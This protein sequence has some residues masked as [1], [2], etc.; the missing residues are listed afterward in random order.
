ML[1]NRRQ[2]RRRGGRANLALLLF[3]ALSCSHDLA[4][5]GLVRGMIEQSSNVVH[6]QWIEHFRDLFLVG[7]VKSPFIRNPKISS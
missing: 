2:A 7:E 4:S 5:T 1:L 6:K 3:A